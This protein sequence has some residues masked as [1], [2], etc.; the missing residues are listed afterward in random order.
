MPATITDTEYKANGVWIY[1]DVPA[2]A[3]SMRIELS[4][5][6]AQTWK[7]LGTTTGRSYR[8]P[9]N[10][11]EGKVHIRAV[12]LNGKKEAEFAQEYPVYITH[13]PPHY[14]EGLRLRLDT[15]EVHLSWGQVLGAEKYGVYRRK[16]GE[17]NFLKIFEG[18]TNLYSDKTATGTVKPFE[19]PGKSENKEADYANIT[20]YEYAVTTINGKGESVLSPVENSDPASWNNWYP[21]TE[22]KFK[23]RSAF[24]ME[25]YVYPHMMPEMYYPD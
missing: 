6:H 7:T 20:I 23:R 12:A 24:W 11:K 17:T 3:K 2:S 16:S 18:K 4:E 25:P 5:D 22:L 15:D 1:L 8:L 14:P 10:L 13:E 19:L 21:Q 9:A